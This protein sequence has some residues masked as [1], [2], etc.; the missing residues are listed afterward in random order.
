FVQAT[1]VGSKGLSCEE[2][3]RNGIAAEGIEDEQ[4]E[5]LWI[6]AVG[7]AF[8]RETAV[9]RNYLNLSGGIGKICEVGRVRGKGDQ[10]RIDFIK[11]NCVSG[12][13][14]GGDGSDTEA[15]RADVHSRAMS[16]EHGRYRP[17]ECL[18]EPAA[19]GIVSSR[20]AFVGSVLQLKAMNNATVS[21]G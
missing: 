14:I 15:D 1:K 10:L 11:T 3:Y 13:G 12:A 2:M 7:F 21:E 16:G 19:G 8:K 9:A 18:I 6:Q 4:V 20:Y 17:L 5:C